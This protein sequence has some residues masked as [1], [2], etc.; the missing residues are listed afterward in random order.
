MAPGQQRPPPFLIRA[1]VKGVFAARHPQHM[2]WP[3]LRTIVLSWLSPSP[4]AQWPLSGRDS[5]TQ[6]GGGCLSLCLSPGTSWGSRP[7]TP[8]CPT[9]H[10]RLQPCPARPRPSRGLVVAAGTPLLPGYSATPSGLVTD[11]SPHLSPSRSP[12]PG[13]PLRTWDLSP[14]S[15]GVM[16]SGV[17]GFGH[18]CS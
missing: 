12:R 3:C 9:E 14:S 18:C 2:R 15:A 6:P 5:Q 17:P 13:Q 10:S 8:S 16:L 1:D 4:A 11:H 7:D